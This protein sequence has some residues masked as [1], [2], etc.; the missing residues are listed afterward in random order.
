MVLDHPALLFGRRLIGSTSA[1]MVSTL[2]GS[3]C[4]MFQLPI[5]DGI[6][7]V[8]EIFQLISADNASL[9][10]MTLKIPL[11]F[12]SCCRGELNEA[13]FTRNIQYLHHD[14]Y[15]ALNMDHDRSIRKT[16][17]S[18]CFQDGNFLHIPTLIIRHKC[19]ELASR[20]R[21]ITHVPP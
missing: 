1:R 10:A 18:E 13:G 5:I 21:I 15:A 3:A 9:R 6:L 8:L 14:P 4:S 2:A 16:R 20:M 7:G 17:S 12:H 19:S 11:E